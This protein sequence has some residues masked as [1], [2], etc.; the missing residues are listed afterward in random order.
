MVKKKYKYMFITRTLADGGS[1]RFVATF[2]G[3]LAAQEKEV[4]VVCWNRGENEYS[5]DK[6]VN[7]IYLPD[8]KGN[9]WRKLYRIK[10]IK[11]VIERVKPDFVVPF[12]EAVIFCSMVALNG[13]KGKLIYTQRNSPWYKKNLNFFV[14]LLRHIVVWKADAIMTQTKEQADFFEKYKEKVWIVPNPV[15]EVFFDL[16]KKTYSDRIK[17]IIMV[18]RLSE[19]KNYELALRCIKRLI[20][21]YPELVLEIYGDG[22][23]KKHLI[24]MIEELDLK[25][26]CRLMGRSSC[27]E[28]QIIHADLFL[29]TST[30][31]GMPNALM[32][33]MAL[34]IPCISSNCKTGPSD[35][36]ESGITGILFEN[37]SLES[38]YKAIDFMMCNPDQTKNMGTNGRK[39]MMEHYTLTNTYDCFLKMCDEIL[40]MR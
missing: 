27:I 23:E 5:I 26:K 34:G 40:Q 29:L 19:E 35:L 22:E 39:Y 16:E 9:F 3:Y 24:N 38:L 32:E 25:E 17:K 6:R 20:I 14:Q 28:E 18:G 12:M 15:N 7:L 21:Q 31:E 1:E 33:A 2:S 36:I 11:N 4:Y 10:D 13:K 30:S 37:E 8:R